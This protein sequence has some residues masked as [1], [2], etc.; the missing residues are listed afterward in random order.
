M[1][2]HRSSGKGL[3]RRESLQWFLVAAGAA[4]ALDPEAFLGCGSASE[5][6]GMPRIGTDP[7]LINPLVPWERTMTEAQL[8]TAAALCEVIIPRDE[9]S[10][11][12][13]EVGVHEFI[14]EWIS[15]PYPRH[16]ADRTL[17]LEGLEWLEAESS[18][19]FEQ[20]FVEL[21]R[22]QKHAI[23]DDICLL[24]RP[25]GLSRYL[26]AIGQDSLT[27]AARFFARFRDLTAGG[28]YTTA[29]G[30]KDLQYIGN[31]A[32]IAFP[33]PPAEVLKHFG[34]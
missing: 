25:K 6:E 32:R 15:A 7:D 33:G 31:V 19:R 20:P 2:S 11:S 14:D 1:N 8:A 23:C 10:P 24:E 34:L 27:K 28:F 12:A 13:S 4:Y 30:M 16:R 3:T 5:F 26:D 9:R 21:T 17:I 22:R 29:E 18:R